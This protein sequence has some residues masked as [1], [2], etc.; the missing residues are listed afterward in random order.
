MNFGH[1]VRRLHL[2]LGISLLPW[3]F[4]YGI[5]SIPFAHPTWFKKNPPDWSVR[6]DRTYSIEVPE[7]SELRPAGERIMRDAGLNGA[8]GT[9]REKD[10]TLRVYRHDFWSS[11]RLSY[12]P[13]QTRLLAED[14]V[15]RWSEFLTG[16]HARGGFAQP[17]ILHD[18]WGIVVDIVSVGILL[19]IAS[20]IYLWWQIRPHRGWGWLALGG[21]AA[22]FAFFLLAL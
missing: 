4:M 2:Y 17:S 21:G 7:G 10:G 9:S 14:R 8:F 15:F 5:S 13:E 3:F 6:F 11:T 12:F 20:G 1:F 16:M 18:A 19:W 22:S